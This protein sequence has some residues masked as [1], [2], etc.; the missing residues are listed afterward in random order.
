MGRVPV[1]PAIRA[2]RAVGVEPEPVAYHY[3]AGGAEEAAAALGL[4]PATV[5]KTIVVSAD[6][7]PRLVLMHGDR[8]V[9]LRAVGRVVDARRVT[10]ARV[11]WPAR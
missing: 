5:V 4:D 6:G 2:L 10:A 8:E 9:S 11:G 1:T 7:E 3:S